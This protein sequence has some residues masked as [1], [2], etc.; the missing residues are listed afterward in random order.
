MENLAIVVIAFNRVNSLDRL[1]KS[2]NRLIVEREQKITLYIS[3]DRDKNDSK[4][5]KEVVECARNFKW[6]F[7][8]K[9]V[10]FRNENM[11]LRK[12]I[13]SCGD[14]TRKYENI[15]VLEDDLVVSP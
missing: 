6:K 7:G 10:N 12:H 3:I 1:L 2:L 13:L 9:V 4:E 11:G 5:N 15:I 8:E 14:L